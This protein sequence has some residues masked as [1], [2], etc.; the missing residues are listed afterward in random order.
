MQLCG[1]SIAAVSF[2][3]ALASQRIPAVVGDVRLRYESGHLLVGEARRRTRF[4]PA[5]LLAAGTVA[6][7]AALVTLLAP[8]G[9]GSEHLLPPLT[10]GAVAAILVGAASYADRRARA[11]TGFA[12]DFAAELLRLDAPNRRGEPLTLKVPFNDV[13]GTRVTEGKGGARTLWVDFTWKGE[14]RQAALVEAAPPSDGSPLE[15]LERVVR[16]AFGLGRPRDLAPRRAVEAD[17]PAGPE[18]PSGTGLPSPRR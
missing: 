8:S 3:E 4:R 15:R 14:P 17:A 7:L 1:I 10:L 12:L 2:E 18:G 11:R 9:P 6:A 16:A 13:R 5:M